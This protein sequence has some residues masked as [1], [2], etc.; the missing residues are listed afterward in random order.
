MG[1]G[2]KRRKGG[3]ESEGERRREGEHT[4]YYKQT[5]LSVKPTRRLSDLLLT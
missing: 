5:P 2:R 4:A 3:R 1:G